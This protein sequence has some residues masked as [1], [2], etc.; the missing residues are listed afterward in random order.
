MSV[1]HNIRE[2]RMHVPMS[3]RE[4]ADKLGVTQGV[5]SQWEIGNKFPRTRMLPKL[6]KELGCSIEELLRERGA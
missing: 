5:V 2:A 3:Q 1:G 6:A 4:L